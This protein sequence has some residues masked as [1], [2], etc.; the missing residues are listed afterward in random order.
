MEVD[1]DLQAQPVPTDPERPAYEFEMP[2]AGGIRQRAF[3]TVEGDDISLYY[4]RTRI[5]GTD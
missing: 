5:H 4:G 2:A 3:F 1:G